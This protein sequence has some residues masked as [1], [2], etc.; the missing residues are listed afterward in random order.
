[1]YIDCCEIGDIVKYGTVKVYDPLKIVYDFYAIVGGT[2]VQM[3]TVMG[4]L[5][6]IVEYLSSVYFTVI[7]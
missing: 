5:R 7:E 1:M 2:R 3:Y 6:V 4:R